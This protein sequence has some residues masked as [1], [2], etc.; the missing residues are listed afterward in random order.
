MTKSEFILKFELS[1]RQFSKNSILAA[2]FHEVNNLLFEFERIFDRF[3]SQWP[4]VQSGTEITDVPIHKVDEAL[5][6]KIFPC[7]SF[8][9]NADVIITQ[10]NSQLLKNLINNSLEQ[11]N[12]SLA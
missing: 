11:I 6:S 10:T 7:I 4:I 5:L 8:Q 12:Q 2:F 9:N 3:N 1:F